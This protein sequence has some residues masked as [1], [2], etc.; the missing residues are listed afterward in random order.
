MYENG[1]AL[2]GLQIKPNFVYLIYMI[3]KWF[4]IKWPPMVDTPW[5]QTKPNL[6]YL[7]YMYKEYLALNNQQGFE[8]P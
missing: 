1:L 3:K 2:K 7:I 5:N 6:I 4:G 8:M